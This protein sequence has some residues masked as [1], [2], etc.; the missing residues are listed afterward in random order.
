MLPKETSPLNRWYQKSE[1]R[2]VGGQI[3]RWGRRRGGS[4]LNISNEGG[5][6]LQL[7]LSR[8]G[9]AS[10]HRRR[11]DGR[12]VS[13]TL[14]AVHGQAHHAPAQTVVLET[15]DLPGLGCRKSGAWTQGPFAGVTAT[16]VCRQRRGDEEEGWRKGRFPP[17]SF[18]VLAHGTEMSSTIEMGGSDW[19][20]ASGPLGSPRSR[21]A[22]SL[23]KVQHT[24]WSVGGIFW[25]RLVPRHLA[26]RNWG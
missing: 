1:Q 23:S 7:A 9:T 4:I 17:G 25:P 22:W 19:T 12:G 16:G 14:G 24:A 20:G 8:Q 5:R 15:L 6:R 3:C 2:E 26:R 18:G 13:R 11:R 10:L 21:L